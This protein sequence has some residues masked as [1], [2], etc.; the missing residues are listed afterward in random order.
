MTNKVVMYTDGACRGNP[1]PG[2]WGVI[3]SYR[4]TEK[5]L[6]GFDPETTNNRMELTAVIEGLR[7]LKRSC[8]V[9]L[10][11]DSKYV[12][13]GINE[14]I[15]NWKS[16]GWKTAAKKRVK[17]V[18]LW[19]RLEQETG[20]HRITWHWVKGHSGIRGN[21]MADRLANQAIDRRNR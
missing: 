3:L 2:G 21:E 16:N 5:T 19:Q 8:E 14:W 17:N 7:A 18:D 13:Q 10:K 9:E 15:D 6:N 4:D 12:L 1:G 11:T 20:R